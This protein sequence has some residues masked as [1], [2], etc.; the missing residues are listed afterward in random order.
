MPCPYRK[1]VGARHC[2]LLHLLRL[3]HSDANGFDIIPVLP[4]LILDISQK[5]REEQAGCLFHN[6]YGRGI[7][8]KNHQPVFRIPAAIPLIVNRA[9]RNNS[10][11]L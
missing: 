4:E 9:P 5:S 6:N 2:R 8:L 10:P 7:L 1:I 11:L 3:D